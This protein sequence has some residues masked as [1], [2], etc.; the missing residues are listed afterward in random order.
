MQ[1][2]RARRFKNQCFSR[3]RAEAFWR[4]RINFKKVIYFLFIISFYAV[5]LSPMKPDDE[6][7]YPCR[8]HRVV[9]VAREASLIEVI[10]SLLKELE[11]DGFIELPEEEIAEL[12]KEL[13]SLHLKLKLPK[14]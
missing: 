5:N 3:N 9:S 2:K 1:M 10:G 13:R 11:E 7:S 6:V 12:K 14:F 8:M 4:R